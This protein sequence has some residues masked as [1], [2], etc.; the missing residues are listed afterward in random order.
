M[1]NSQKF[2]FYVILIMS[3]M[4]FGAFIRTN[5]EE[6]NN[7]KLLDS[8]IQHKLDSATEEAYLRT[9]L[10]WNNI[11]FWIKH[12]KIKYP[13]ILRA[14]IVQECGWKLNS[15]KAIQNGNICG[16]TPSSNKR[17]HTYTYV[18]NGH[19][20]Y[21]NFIESIRDYMFWQRQ[22]YKSGDYYKFLN[23]IRYAEDTLYVQKIK[24]IIAKQSKNEQY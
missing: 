22:N 18:E 4:S 24:Y 3:I 20:G 17:E 2:L 16:M 7:K 5:F 23:N 13:E 1:K 14:Q 10:N 6:E 9:S 15:K 11:D 21:P 12:F 19:C 8:L